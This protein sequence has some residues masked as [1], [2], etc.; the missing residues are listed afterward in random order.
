MTGSSP[1]ASSSASTPA[2]NR[3][4]LFARQLAVLLLVAGIAG[5]AWS[6]RQRW[7]PATHGLLVKLKLA[8]ETETKA[9]PPPRVVSV[10]TATVTRRSVDYFLTGLGTVTP[11]RTVTIRPRVEGELIKIAFT[12][13]QTVKEG[14][15]LAQID[16]RLWQAQ[17]EQARGQLARDDAVLRSTNKTLLRYR[18]LAEAKKITPQELDD[19]VALTEQAAATVR[20]DAALVANA[21]LQLSYCE[22]SAPIDGRIGLRLVDQG[23]VVR[24]SDPEGLAVITQLKPIAVVF[25]IPQDEIPRI[26]ARMPSAEGLVVEAFDRDLREKLAVGTLAAVDNQVDPATGTLKLKAVFPNDDEALFPNQFVNVKLLVETE[27]DAIVAPTAAIQRGP[28]SS[29]AYLVQPDG[30]VARQPLRIGGTEGTDT[31]IREGLT[32]GDQ[33]VVQGLDQ[34]RP[35]S[36]VS[37]KSQGQTPAPPGSSA[38]DS[39]SNRPQVSDRTRPAEATG[40]IP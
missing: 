15:L 8:A 28:D 27:P 38:D 23:N 4:R 29:F 17:L 11:F 32:P 30:T 36:K 21:E 33:V 12:E 18:Q 19:Q 26:L 31:V 9:P 16:P 1:T 22:I 20:I 34:L 24:Q 13:G 14:D 3:G 39:S 10:A 25:T 2:T 7:L 5:A 37:I 40:R 6:T 35:G